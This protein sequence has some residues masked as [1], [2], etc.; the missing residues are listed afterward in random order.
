MTQEKTPRD[1]S[2]RVNL[3]GA[4]DLSELKYETTAL[5]GEA[6]GAPAA[7]EY[8]IDL[9]TKNFGDFVD[10]SRDYPL[11][12]M[13]WNPKDERMFDYARQLGAGVNALEGRLQLGRLDA[14]RYPDIARTLQA[15]ALPALYAI[16]AGRPMPL[17]E[18]IPTSEEIEQI[19]SQVLPQIVAMAEEAGVT[20]LAPRREAGEDGESNADADSVADSASTPK[21]DSDG[22]D[23]RRA[24]REAVEEIPEE[25]RVAYELAQ[26]GE[27]K[28]AAEEYEKILDANPADDRAA[29]ERAKALLL[30]RTSDRN[31]QE[32]RREAADSP[33]DE[34]AQL[35]MADVDMYEG[36]V[37]DAFNRLL[38]FA[39]DHPDSR[40]DVRQRMLEY[41]LICGEKD[42]RVAAARR[43]MA[44]LLY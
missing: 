11:I 22:A 13:V 20:G 24:E 32:T 42:S 38:D 29:R 2:S 10:S 17:L 9:D 12:L 37:D 8:V 35:A 44:T 19:N 23:A 16:L 41:F 33:G 21:R 30:S 40:E 36:H 43:R 39:Q 25:H 3:A 1:I 7:G 18:G 4:V 15:R 6:G 31:V 26:K 27:Y 5:P 28:E 14:T 34:D